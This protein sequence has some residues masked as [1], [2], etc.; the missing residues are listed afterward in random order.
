MA[1]ATLVLGAAIGF[2]AATHAQPSNS[3]NTDYLECVIDH[4]DKVGAET[5]CVFYG[6]TWDPSHYMYE[7]SLDRAES[8]RSRGLEAMP[9]LSVNP[10]PPAPPKVPKVTTDMPVVSLG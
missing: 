8:L 10:G 2:A 5:C 3:V 1:S 7:C 4:P 9:G 6:G